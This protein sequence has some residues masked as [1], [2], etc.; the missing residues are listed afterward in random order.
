MA[1]WNKDDKPVK[2]WGKDDEVVTQESPGWFQPGSK[3]EAAVRGFSQAATLGFGDEIQA[4][5]RTIGDKRT[6]QELKDTERAA[7]SAAYEANPKSYIAGGVVGAIPQ[8]ANI[9]SVARNAAPVI[10]GGK[11]ILGQTAA[12]TAAGVGTGG[13]YGAAQGAGNA[14]TMADIPKQAAIQGTIGAATGGLTGGLTGKVVDKSLAKAA[15]TMTNKPVEQTAS[16]VLPTA[17]NQV[18]LPG[19]GALGNVGRVYSTGD[20]RPDWSTDPYSAM[21]DTAKAAGIGAAAGWGIKKAGDLGS[22]AASSIP[23]AV[24][25]VVD[26]LGVNP[27]TFNQSIIRNTP[28]GLPGS[29]IEKSVTP[30]KGPFDKISSY[31]QQQGLDPNDPDE[32]RRAAMQLASTEQGRA[33]MNDE[34]FNG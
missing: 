13:L 18:T 10:V 34:N 19:L 28:L 2:D 12:S 30:P 22:A 14:T 27:E 32:K 8:A 6:V 15:A 16:T 23:G 29:I 11:T 26:K 4:Y 9:A 5:L 21:V 25:K 24:G 7:N 17:L 1:D 3:S 20:E 33:S 31:L